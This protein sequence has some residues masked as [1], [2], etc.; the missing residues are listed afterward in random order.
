MPRPQLDFGTRKRSS[1]QVDALRKLNRCQAS[2]DSDKENAAP[3]PGPSSVRRSSSAALSK[4]VGPFPETSHAPKRSDYRRQLVETQ[5]QLSTLREDYSNLQSQFTRVVSNAEAEKVKLKKEIYNITRRMRRALISRESATKTSRNHLQQMAKSKK[6][7]EKTQSRLLAQRESAHRSEKTYLEN[8]AAQTE[9]MLKATRAANHNLES[10][11]AR[12]SKELAKKVDLVAVSSR[13]INLMK[14]GIYTPETRALLRTLRVHG[15]PVKAV[16]S[17]IKA[18]AAAWN[19]KLDAV[20]S[21]DTA[22]RA[23]TEGLVAGEL[24][25]VEEACTAGIWTFSG[26]GTTHQGIQYEARTMTV[27]APDYNDP[28]AAPKTVDRYLQVETVT[29]HTANAQVG[30]FLRMLQAFTETHN[31]FASYTGRE[32]VGCTALVRSLM[33]IHTD[34]AAD[35]KKFASMVQAIKTEASE[36]YLRELTLQAKTEAQLIEITNEVTEQTI[37]RMGGI[38]GWLSLSGEEKMRRIEET[39]LAFIQVYGREAYAQLPDEEKLMTSRIVWAG[40]AMHKEMNCFKVA[41]KGAAGYWESVGKLGPILLM[42][43]SNAT[44]AATSDA[45]R[46]HVNQ[47]SEGG[48]IKL[49]SIA[50]AVFNH[51]EDTRGE[52]DQIRVW[53]EKFVGLLLQ[54]P[55]VSNTR[56]GSHGEAA[57]VL[58]LFLPEFCTYIENMSN[59]KGKPGLNHM[60]QNL[61]DGLHDVPTLTELAALTLYTL[62]FSRPYMKLLCDPTMNMLDQADL[63]EDAK[64][65]LLKLA[66]DP[67]HVLNPSTTPDKICF[68]GT[69]CLKHEELA[70][71]R[72]LGP[73]LPHLPQIFAWAVMVLLE[74]WERF[75]AEFSDGKDKIFVHT[76]N[77]INEGAVGNRKQRLRATPNATKVHVNTLEM[78][79]RNNVDGFIRTRI[80]DDPKAQ[81]FLHEEACRR[82]IGGV[83]KQRRARIASA[84]DEKAAENVAREQKRKEARNKKAE[85]LRQLIATTALIMDTEALRSKTNKELDAQ[86]EV[87]RSTGNQVP[88]KLAVGK[89]QLKLDALAAAIARASQAIIGTAGDIDIDSDSGESNEI[90]EYL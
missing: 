78:I 9:A 22:Q 81:Q 58:L 36:Q 21:A 40:C 68:N 76:T 50:G 30:N 43:K 59:R 62:C 80:G 8:C 82:Q 56:Y 79:R 60:E 61:W 39:H 37:T 45:A 38:L 5:Q 29:S 25:V 14:L 57:V 34:H 72:S 88:C 53:F 19:L 2:K 74:A 7:A 26:N 1:R 89:K 67:D 4:H 18:F 3:L 85:D 86:L 35:Q 64:A 65:H 13:S 15:V 90:D 47:V 20:P 63:H 51:R 46:K 69:V 77:C 49:T 12:L 70:A 23:V 16:P 83:E 11:L 84:L 28:M 48:A 27:K 41:A 73:Q 71:I 32:Q 6:K 24:Q 54:F 33:A 42:N 55:D 52:G 75:T 17:V 87:W 66:N 31:R 10:Q 44:A